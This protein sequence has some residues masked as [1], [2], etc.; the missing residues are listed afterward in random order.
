MVFKQSYWIFQIA[1]WSLYT[2]FGLSDYLLIFNLNY[3]EIEL[4]ILNSIINIM[5][6]ISLTHF[7]RV[8]FKQY[9]W[10]KLSIPQL[11]LRS[12]VGVLVITSLLTAVN[13]SLDESII[14]TSQMNWI[15]KD[16]LYIINLSK[17]VL[18][19]VLIYIFYAYS[20]ERRIDAIE[21]IKLQSSIEESE[22]KILRAQINPHFMFNALNSI[23]ALV[24]EEPSKAQKGITQLSNILRSALVA[25]RKTTI[26]LKEELKTIEDYLELE[27]VRY[28]ERLQIK[29]EV[30]TNTLPIQVPP[31]MLQTLV[32][33]AIKHGVQKASR[34]GF[35]EINT[36][37]IGNE[38]LIKIRNTG[39]LKK[40]ENNN[41]DGG[42]GLKNTEKRLKLL[43]GNKAEFEIFQEDK[44]VVT[45]QIKIPIT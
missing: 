21:K 36:T 30:D 26:S 27:K 19:W 34:W 18:I 3:E 16:L 37:K 28:E 39:V 42:F 4:L 44:Q 17:P 24:I 38:I 41:I 10:I 40:T 25:D 8:I 5:V 2:L 35:V 23:R 31:M 11:I 29:W 43:Y 32:E 45:A 15:I 20:N 13:I 1:G 12:A 6:G 22:A 14:D 7:F 33:N 9:N